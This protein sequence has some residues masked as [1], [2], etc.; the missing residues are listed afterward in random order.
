MTAKDFQLKKAQG[1]G[2]KQAL[3]I[4]LD[5]AFCALAESIHGLTDDQFQAFP[6]ENQHNIVTLSEHCLQCL[7]LYGCEVHGRPLTLKAEKRF[8]IWHFS[9]DQLRADMTHLPTV[10]EELVRIAA[11]RQAVMAV[12]ENAS[13]EELGRPNMESWWF[14]DQPDRVQ[15]DAF[16]RATCHTMAHVRQIWFLRGLLGLSD[17]EGWPDQHWA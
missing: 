14:K 13:V 12:L 11:V 5:E 7:D 2:L 1:I 4:G 17:M 8:D 16:M 15:A 9:P 6:L 10:A 3:A